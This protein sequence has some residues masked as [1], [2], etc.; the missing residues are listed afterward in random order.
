MF[1]N[2]FFSILYTYLA[3]RDMA[4]VKRMMWFLGK[5]RR[6]TTWKL[7]LAT[8]EWESEVPKTEFF[9]RKCLLWCARIGYVWL[10]LAAE[11]T[12]DPILYLV[13]LENSI[14]PQISF[15]NKGKSLY[16]SS[17][18]VSVFS[19]VQTHIQNIKIIYSMSC[20]NL[21]VADIKTDA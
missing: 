4:E 15:N 12:L 2:Y 16:Y 17:P 8:L 6:Y 9:R 18:M 1:P 21:E 14:K 3:G 11:T 19:E 5:K 20:V 7:H 13:Q 10:D